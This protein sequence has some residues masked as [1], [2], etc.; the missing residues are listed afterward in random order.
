MNI[1]F[2]MKKDAIMLRLIVKDGDMYAA[3]IFI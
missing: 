3:F 2:V 1:L